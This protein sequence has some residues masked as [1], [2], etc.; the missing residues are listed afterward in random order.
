MRSPITGRGWGLWWEEQPQRQ[1]QRQAASRNGVGVLL[2]CLPPSSPIS[3]SAYFLLHGPVTPGDSTNPPNV[4]ASAT[5]SCRDEPRPHSLRRTLAHASPADSAPCL[6]RPRPSPPSPL[7]RGRVAAGH[8]V[9]FPGGG[10]PWARGSVHYGMRRRARGTGPGGG[11]ERLHRVPGEFVRDHGRRVSA[12][13]RPI[14]IADVLFSRPAGE[15][16]KA[17]GPLAS[18]ATRRL[19]HH[20]IARF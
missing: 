17:A 7:S 11:A 1:R 10:A 12:H 13:A 4:N 16:C 5:L 3:N 9:L 19:A 20:V 18:L 8:S 2:S 15:A 14:Q 6:R